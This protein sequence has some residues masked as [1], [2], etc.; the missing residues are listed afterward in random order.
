[1][2][3]G[4]IECF[5]LVARN[6][7]FSR[8][9]EELFLSQSNATM[10]INAMEKELGIK[11]FERTRKGAMLTEAGE[12][13]YEKW[14]QAYKDMQIAMLEGREPMHPVP[15]RISTGEWNVLGWI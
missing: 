2:D 8:A 1:M 4:K 12:Y 13:L 6:Q 7:S 14:G 5:L 11:L 15:L 3:F 9:A 10:K